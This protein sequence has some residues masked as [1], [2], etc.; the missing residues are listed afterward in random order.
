[1][2]QHPSGRHQMETAWAIGALLLA[3][4]LQPAFAT[5]QDS[6]ADV[7]PLAVGN[8]WTFHYSTLEWDYSDQT[9][10]DSG[11]AVY[12]LISTSPEG[13]SVRWTMMERR[14]VYHCYDYL[15]DYYPR[16]CWA[17]TDSST[18]EII[19]LLD[20]R[21]RLY[22]PEAE[23]QTWRSPFAWSWEVSDTTAIYRFSPVDTAGYVSFETHDTMKYYPSLY[24]LTFRAGIGP[25]AIRT[26]NGF[27]VGVDLQSDHHLIQSIITDAPGGTGEAIPGELALGQNYPNPFNPT[28]SISFETHVSGHV[29][30]RVFDLLGREVATLV[31]GNRSSGLHRVD[32]DASRLASGVYL[33]RIEADGVSVTRRA[34]LLR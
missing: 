34:L 26:T 2:T 16:G 20:G 5:A 15:W 10:T 33:Y 30:L 12:T 24:T 29:R 31:D 11:T 13:D 8:Q 21:H 32:W 28:T 25:T 19:E 27:L 14:S 6:L 7:M 23:S 9:S 17:V 4:F 1:M 3:S 18:F 22:R